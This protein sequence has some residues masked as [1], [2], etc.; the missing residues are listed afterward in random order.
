[1]AI[2]SSAAVRKSPSTNTKAPLESLAQ[3]S[4]VPQYVHY[5]KYY[6]KQMLP[7]NALIAP[8]YQPLAPR[9]QACKSNLNLV[10]TLELFVNDNKFDPNTFSKE[11]FREKWNDLDLVLT[12]CHKKLFE[13]A[14]QEAYCLDVQSILS[15]VPKLDLQEALQIVNKSNIEAFCQQFPE[16]VLRSIAEAT[17]RTTASA[18]DYLSNLFHSKKN[19]VKLNKAKKSAVSHV[20]P[21]SFL[22]KHPEL[23]C[24]E[25]EDPC[26]CPSKVLKVAS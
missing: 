20:D 25:P 6:C 5:F 19:V 15:T 21:T 1:M 18:Y 2:R 8:D 10:K 3:Q 23:R 14:L 9:P 26:F 7:F 16:E 13:Q 11:F 22:N 17:M 12:F 24:P 4:Q